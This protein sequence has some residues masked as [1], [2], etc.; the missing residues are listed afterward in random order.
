[1]CL[2]VIGVAPVKEVRVEG[3]DALLL[4][5]AA[6]D[7]ILEEAGKGGRELSCVVANPAFG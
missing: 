3:R 1:M 2:L 6:S 7:K 4:D 5:E